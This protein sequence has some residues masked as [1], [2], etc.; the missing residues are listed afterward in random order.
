MSTLIISLF[1]VQLAV[2]MA[3]AIAMLLVYSPLKRIVPP[4]RN[5]VAVV[6]SLTG[7]IG[8]IVSNTKS[9]LGR[10]LVNLSRVSKLFRS[11]GKSNS[12]RFSLTKI[13]AALVTGRRLL[14][15]FKLFRQLGKNKFWGTFRMFML[16]GPIVVPALTAIKRFIRRPATA[17]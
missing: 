12:P 5:L 4:V 2:L 7:T 1:I 9:I 16:L 13:F 3:V 15:V 8:G 6:R 14:G 11:R 17:G 10:A